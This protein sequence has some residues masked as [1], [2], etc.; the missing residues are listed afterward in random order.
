MLVELLAQQPHRG[1]PNSH[2]LKTRL[3][4]DGSDVPVGLIQVV[5]SEGRSKVQ[6]AVSVGGILRWS[7]QG[8][9]LWWQSR[10]Y[11]VAGLDSGSNAK[12]A[13]SPS[14]PSNPG[15]FQRTCERAVEHLKAHER[16]V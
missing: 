13:L 6:E 11:A 3:Y 8:S 9:D 15:T 12:Y 10:P 14:D 5:S 16:I 1:T 4:P 2:R 7:V